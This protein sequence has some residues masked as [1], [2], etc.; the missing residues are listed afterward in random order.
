MA[1]LTKNVGAWKNSG[2]REMIPEKLRQ[3]M[4]ELSREDLRQTVRTLSMLTKTYS[5][6]TAVKAL[7]EGFSVNRTHFSDAA[8]LAARMMNYG[9]D[10][11]P[12]TGPDLSYY[13][14]LL[15]TEVAYGD[16]KAQNKSVSNYARLATT[17]F[18]HSK[19]WS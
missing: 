7:E 11:P 19:W 13:D 4:D 3:N 5:F 12:E 2:V 15:Q 16:N 10:T 8:V 9:L 14:Q 1:T 6:E 18:C 17:S